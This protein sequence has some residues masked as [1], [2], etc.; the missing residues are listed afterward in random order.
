MSASD[1]AA[2]L[3]EARPGSPGLKALAEARRHVGL[4]ESPAGSNRTPFGRWFGA[5]GV[6]WCAIFVSYCFNVGAGVVL[7]GGGSSG[8]GPGCNALG[9]AY[10]PTLRAWLEETGQLGQAPPRPGD[11]AI[12]DWDGGQPDHTGIVERSLGEGR[13]V[14]IEG[15]TGIGNDTNGGEVMRRQRRLAAVDCFGRIRARRAG[16]EADDPGYT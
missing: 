15:N 3:E 6:P 13:F 9:C 4:R 7:G 5:D 16:E 14:T 8:D 2:A 10:V 12:F 1:V 11:I